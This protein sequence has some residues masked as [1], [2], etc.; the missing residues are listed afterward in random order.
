M[1]YVMP[2]RH[3]TKRGRNDAYARVYARVAAAAAAAAAA[4][5]RLAAA[6]F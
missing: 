3:S 4:D 1:G 2:H 5:E 6:H